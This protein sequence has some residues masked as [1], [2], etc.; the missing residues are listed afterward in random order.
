MI[1]AQAVLVP[2]RRGF[3]AGALALMAAPVVVKASSLMRVAPTDIIRPN[4]LMSVNEITREAVRLFKNSNVF[5]E[6]IER[7][8]R[9]AFEFYDGAQW[10]SAKIG[11]QL[12]IRLPADYVVTDGPA[13]S[14]QHTPDA[15][16]YLATSP[17]ARG[18]IV[19]D[20]AAPI[21]KLA[22]AVAAPVVVAK[23]L[24]QPVTRRF[25]GGR[26]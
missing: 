8:Y 20:L 24:E 17:V 14:I 13:L 26:K 5:I 10:D 9:E 12:R 23:A 19:R 15:F 3:V 4:S 1:D 2:S 6:E 7:Q 21:D 16:Q 22:L 18:D 11:T 25:W